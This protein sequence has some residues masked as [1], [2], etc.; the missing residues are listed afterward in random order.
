MA[1]RKEKRKKT[2]TMVLSIS[3]AAL[4]VLSIGG[5]IVNSISSNSQSSN[6]FKLTYSGK[7][8]RFEGKLDSYGNPYYEVTTDDRMF[9]AFYLPEQLSYIQHDDHALNLI[10]DS[11][12]FWITFDPETA[13]LTSVD[14][15][16]YDFIL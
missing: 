7:D 11:Y 2:F 16:R 6:K 3:L 10:K 4:M 12:T 15:L 9:T 14:F 1:N 8:F 5:Y 13:D